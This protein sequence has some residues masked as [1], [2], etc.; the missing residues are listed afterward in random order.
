VLRA[1]ELEQ[2]GPAGPDASDSGSFVHAALHLVYSALEGEGALRPGASA[3]HALE[4]AEAL[5]PGA[6]EEASA[7]VRADVQARHP[8]IWQAYVA[9]VRGAISDF[10]TRDL[11][12]LLPEGVARI[13]TEHTVR[14][15][16]PLADGAEIDV[17][18]RIDRLVERPDGS[19]RIGDYKTGRTFSKAL[20][21]S[22]VRAGRS[23]QVPL[24]AL[25]AARA[26]ERDA[27]LGE[28]LAVLRHPARDRDDARSEERSLPLAELETLARAPLAEIAGLLARG[29][30]PFRSDEYD[31]RFCPYTI[32]CR[33]AQPESDARSRAVESRSAYFALGGRGS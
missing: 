24:Y 30:F 23:L 31:C 21:K 10:L 20:A 32:A 25:T 19:L 2:P 18:G 9:S 22:E 6:L 12:T 14:A 11:A 28:V 8:R 16:L 4:R 7:P 29:D 15:R 27:V 33:Y 17:E 1:S 5:L 3:Q 26:L 13:E